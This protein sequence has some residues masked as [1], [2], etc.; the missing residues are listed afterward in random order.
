[1]SSRSAA[2]KLRSLVPPSERPAAPAAAP[3]AAPVAAAAEPAAPAAPLTAEERRRLVVG[4]LKSAAEAR[5]L[6]RQSYLLLPAVVGAYIGYQLLLI[7]TD[8]QPFLGDGALLLPLSHAL[9]P[10]DLALGLTLILLVLALSAGATLAGARGVA[11]VALLASIVPMSVLGYAWVAAT[12]SRDVLWTW[13]FSHLA[14]LPLCAPL[15]SG[16][17]VAGEALWDA[18]ERG[19]LDDAKRDIANDL[20]AAPPAGAARGAADGKAPAA[21]AS[22]PAAA[23]GARRR[24]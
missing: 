23:G 7:S 10:S 8:K 6:W 20:A 9:K 16:G 3:V 21:R 4:A 15:V 12:S 5:S 2:D 18:L 19:M 22:G 24:G 11:R 17:V 14:L 1:M 13:R